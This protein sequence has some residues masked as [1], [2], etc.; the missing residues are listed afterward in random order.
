MSM[1]PLVRLLALLALAAQGA[2]SGPLLQPAT[3]EP[4]PDRDTGLPARAG[5]PA[6]CVREG[7]S[8]DA[9][10]ATCCAGFLCV[11]SRG[12]VCTSRF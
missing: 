2:C 12:A 7:E 1:K 5:A 6:A 11:G 8:C 3:P 10:G 9:P 4:A